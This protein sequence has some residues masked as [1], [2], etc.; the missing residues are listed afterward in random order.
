MLGGDAVGLEGDA[1]GLEG[2]A[3]GMAEGWTAVGEHIG[4]VL[5]SCWRGARLFWGISKY[6]GDNMSIE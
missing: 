2:D 6:I 1:V 4:E 3:V 5:H